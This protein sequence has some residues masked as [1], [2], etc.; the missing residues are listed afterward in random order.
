MEDVR[1][2]KLCQYNKL[3]TFLTSKGVW[4]MQL[5][6]YVSLIGIVLELSWVF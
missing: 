4:R 2:A 1:S 3:G 5:S 6:A